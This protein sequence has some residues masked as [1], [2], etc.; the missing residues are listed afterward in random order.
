[1]DEQYKCDSNV[2]QLI[3]L[4]QIQHS[5]GQSKTCHNAP[6]ADLGQSISD[7]VSDQ[8]HSD[9]NLVRCAVGLKNGTTGPK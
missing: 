2:A 8:M 7:L 3:Q 5:A 9:S 1:M 4:D 6:D